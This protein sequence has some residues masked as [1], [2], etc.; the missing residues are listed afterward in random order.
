MTFPGASILCSAIVNALRGHAVFNRVTAC[1][2]TPVCKTRYDSQP[3]HG[4]FAPGPRANRPIR[5]WPSRSLE[6]LLPVAK[7]PALFLPGTNVL[8]NLCSL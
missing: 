4:L 2:V 1:G 8:A 5:P 7:W 3:V 6:L